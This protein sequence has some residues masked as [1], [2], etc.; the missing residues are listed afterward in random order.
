MVPG[1]QRSRDDGSHAGQSLS[2][3]WTIEPQFR[4]TK[5]LQFGMDLSAT[6]I[7]EPCAVTACCWSRLRHR[8][9]P[10]AGGRRRTPRHGPAVEIQYQQDAHAL[11]VSPGLYAVMSVFN[12]LARTF[13]SESFDFRLILLMQACAVEGGH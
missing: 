12:R 4:D 1:E 7:G 11:A 6:R 9:A 2:H 3:R 8:A 13:S 10:P 5:D